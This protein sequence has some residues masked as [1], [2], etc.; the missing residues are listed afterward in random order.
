MFSLIFFTT[1]SF[2]QKLYLCEKYTESGEPIG[3]GTVWNIPSTGANVYLLYNNGSAIS[4]NIIYYFIDKFNGSSYVQYSDKAVYPDKTKS[5]YVY[6]YKFTEAG[7]YKIRVLNA[8]VKT[9][10]TEYTTIKFK[11][12]SSSSAYT[13]PSNY[14]SG[15]GRNTNAGVDFP[16]ATI[17][18]CTSASGGTPIGESSSFSV[19][20]AGGVVTALINHSAVIN[21]TGLIVDVYRTIDGEAEKFVETVRFDKI[22]T[23]WKWYTFK[24]NF[25]VPAKYKLN[26]YTKESKKI[27]TGFVTI[28]PK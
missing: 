20:G 15:G 17:R 1:Q 26:V 12:G 2:S 6:D 7:Q 28:V 18:F 9:V 24:Y 25:F 22:E 11:D 19:G 3:V 27:I 21:S 5:W 23:H 13:S 10:A 14:S 4:D 16:D 8:A